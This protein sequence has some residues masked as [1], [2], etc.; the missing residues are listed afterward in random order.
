VLDAAS[1]QPL[2]SHVHTSMFGQEELPSIRVIPIEERFAESFHRCL[3]AVRRRPILSHSSTGPQD[4]TSGLPILTHAIRR[5]HEDETCTT[6]RPILRPDPVTVC[7]GG[8]HGVIVFSS[9]AWVPDSRATRS[10]LTA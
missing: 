3:G 9:L 8:A 1:I 7:S 4:G 6:T 5:Q 2:M 10:S